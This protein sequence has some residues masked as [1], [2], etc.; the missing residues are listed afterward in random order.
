MTKPIERHVLPEADLTAAVSS[1]DGWEVTDG[2]LRRSVTASSFASAI[3]LVRKVAIVAEE[4]DHHPDID[5][6][7]RTVTFALTT[8]DSGGITALDID[9]AHQIDHFAGLA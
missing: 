7:W 4:M 8:H 3:E 1:L 5:I 6:R 2:M 9:Q